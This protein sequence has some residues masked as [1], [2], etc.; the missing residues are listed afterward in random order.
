MIRRLAAN[1]FIVFAL[2]WPPTQAAN[3]TDR[4][5]RGDI[6]AMTA[7]IA[8]RNEQAPAGRDQ[9][10]PID[11]PLPRIGSDDARVEVLQFV[12]Y[13][14]GRARTGARHAWKKNAEELS[15]RWRESLPTEV[16]VIRVP[17]AR[18]QQV[19]DDAGHESARTRLRTILTAR[20]LGIED[21]THNQITHALDNDRDAVRTKADARDFFEDALAVTPTRFETAWSSP[22]V[23]NAISQSVRAHRAIIETAVRRGTRIR[24]PTPLIVLVAGE[25]IVSTY[26]V[27]RAGDAFR[28]ANRL[29][30][31]ELTR[32]AKLSPRERRWRAVFTELRLLRPSDIAYNADARPDTPQPIEIDPP[33]PTS[34]PDGTI[35]VEWFFTYLNRGHNRHRTTSWLTSRMESLMPEWAQTIPHADLKRLRMRFTPVS[36]IPGHDGTSRE[37]A[38]MLQTLALGFGYSTTARPGALQPTHVS[39]ALHLAIRGRLAYNAPATIL[40]DDRDVKH[41]LQW[42]RLPAA[43][44]HKVAASGLP[45]LRADAADARFDLLLERAEAKTADAFTDP[46]YPIILI[47]GRYLVTGA[48]AGGYTQAARITNATIKRLLAP[49]RN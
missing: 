48:A 4:L 1:L 20:A 33:L 47:D 43:E 2:L 23:E 22:E 29:I 36:T 7:E 42:A 25:H 9:V 41:L 35:E 24:T 30:N 39:P 13:T 8:W 17:I 5:Y 40:D 32:D 28:I 18:L 12:D 37:Q 19:G 34:T 10:L 31:R 46:A 6:N 26:T 15:R 16:N 21:E 49:H 11:P 3:G 45:T 44:Y 38:R 27:R 14:Y